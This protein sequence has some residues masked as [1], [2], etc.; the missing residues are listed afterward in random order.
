MSPEIRKEVE[1]NRNK[2]KAQNEALIE[3]LREQSKA[4][5]PIWSTTTTTSPNQ[6]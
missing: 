6:K 1:L 4:D 3:Y 2:R 5:K